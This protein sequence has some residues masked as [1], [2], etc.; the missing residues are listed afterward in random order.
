ML[1]GACYQRRERQPPARGSTSAGPDS[2]ANAKYQR[3]WPGR[4]A[5]VCSGDRTT[6]WF[7]TPATPENFPA[8]RGQRHRLEGQP[9]VAEG[10][11]Q[12]EIGA[13]A[14]LPGRNAYFTLSLFNLIKNNLAVADYARLKRPAG[15][16]TRRRSAKRSPRASK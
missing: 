13:K 15:A 5:S 12:Y 2:E 6:G 16:T 3:L 14:Q 4:R 11:T 10:A 9:A 7:S 8:Q 1:A